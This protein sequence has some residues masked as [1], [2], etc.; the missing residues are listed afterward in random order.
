[1]DIVK[2]VGDFLEPIDIGHHEPMDISDV[3][4][5]L[6]DC[7]EMSVDWKIMKADNSARVVPVK[8]RCKSIGFVSVL[9]LYKKISKSPPDKG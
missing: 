1:M 2:L 3:T 7:D 6:R 5:F 4:E 9:S 8:T